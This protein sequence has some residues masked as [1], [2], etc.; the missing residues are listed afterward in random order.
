MFGV[1]NTL[2]ISVFERTREIGM[3]PAVGMTRRQVR[4][5]IRSGSSSPGSPRSRSP[6]T[7]S[8]FPLPCGSLAV[9]VL[10]AIL[11]GMLAAILP[12]R[13]A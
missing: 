6:T 1:I 8:C 3:L 4:R 12:A 9:F 11:A 2:V 10:I 7:T 13:G 5:M